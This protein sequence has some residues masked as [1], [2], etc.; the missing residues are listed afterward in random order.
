M[1]N[2]KRICLENRADCQPLSWNALRKDLNF[3]TRTSSGLQREVEPKPLTL[4]DLGSFTQENMGMTSER[5]HAESRSPRLRTLARLRITG[6]HAVVTL[7]TLSAFGF[8]ADTNVAGHAPTSAPKASTAR[9]G[10]VSTFK[11]WLE[12]G[13]AS[14]YG[15][16]FQGHRTATG[17]KYDMNSLT[18]AH[19][20]LPLGSWLRVTN[21]HNHRS[22]LVRVNDRGPLSDHRVID[23]SYAAAQAVGLQGLAKVKL[24]ALTLQDPEVAQA[25]LAHALLAQFNAFDLPAESR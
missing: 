25:I 6:M 22:V 2:L 16:K 4:F 8:A 17:E 24:E 21:L 10:P 13:Q 14:W 3:Y 9:S 7:T 23:L 19:R 11:H 15:L 1:R 20:S 12:T 5:N 18:C